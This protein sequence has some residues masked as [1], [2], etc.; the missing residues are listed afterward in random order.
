MP[1]ELDDGG[2]A[3]VLAGRPLRHAI[4][5]TGS[6]AVLDRLLSRV[7]GGARIVLVGIFHGKSEINTNAIVERE[8]KLRGCSV[9]ADEQVRA[10]EMLPELAPKLARLVSAPIGLTAEPAAY[11]D[12]IEGRAPALMTIIRPRG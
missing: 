4:E 6:A 9:F 12:L 3:A 1:V 11:Q 5:A 2:L 7:A 8:I 10:V